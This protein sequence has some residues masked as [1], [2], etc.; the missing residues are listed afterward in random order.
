MIITGINSVQCSA[1]VLSSLCLSVKQVKV[2]Q[3]SKYCFSRGRDSFAATVVAGLAFYW[4]VT[5]LSMQTV[6]R[7]TNKREDK[8][9]FQL[10]LLP[11]FVLVC[12]FFQADFS[13]EYYKI[14]ES[15]VDFLLNFEKV[16]L[17]CLLPLANFNQCLALQQCLCFRNLSSEC[18]SPCS[19]RLQMK[20]W[21]KMMKMEVG[22][23]KDF[24]SG[25]IYMVL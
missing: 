21:E 15:F 17:L 1:G 6:M 20:D 24:T 16:F 13:W 19:L 25:H 7:T 8:A 22:V 2:T 9:A 23:Q 4:S 3:N 18:Q 12:S 14:S 5:E 10:I 11:V